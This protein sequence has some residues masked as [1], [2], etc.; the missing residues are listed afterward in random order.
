VRAA[1]DGV[2]SYAA[3]QGDSRGTEIDFYDFTYDGAVSDGQLSGGLGQLTDYELGTSNFRLDRQNLGR[4]G[5]EWLAW[6]NDSS[7]FAAA[8]R[9]Y[10][11]VVF[12]FDQVVYGLRVVIT[13]R[14]TV[15][16]RVGGITGVKKCCDPSVRPSVCQSVPFSDCLVS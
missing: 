13:P 2:L 4:N 9:R 5:Y 10:V 3:R 15:G 1:V 12:Q 11:S 16:E 8:S 6:R 7:A 14:P